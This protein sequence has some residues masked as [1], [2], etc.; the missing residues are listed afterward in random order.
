MMHPN[1]KAFLDMIAVSELGKG[2]IAISDNGYNV[3]VG[4]TVKN[5]ILFKDYT[6]HPNRLMSLNIKGK[7]VASTAAGRY[8]ILFRYYIH[9]RGAL[10]L[11]D[12]GK[13]SQDS[14]ATQLIVECGALEDIR[15]G[16]F[17]IALLKCRSRWASLPGAGYGQH[18]NK[19]GDLKL[20]YLE[21]GGVVTA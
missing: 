20:A 8:Q 17:E 11:R 7:P 5:P 3:I 6:T 21:S 15:A 1:L 9:Y 18:E 4:S 14:I 2:L 19:V 10:K 16:R 12:F 13:D